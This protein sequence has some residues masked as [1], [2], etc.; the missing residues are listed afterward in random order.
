MDK[1]GALAVNA[2]EET[3]DDDV[4]VGVEAVGNEALV[5]EDVVVV[6]GVVAGGGA[7]TGVD[8]F[9]GGVGVALVLAVIAVR[10]DRIRR[11]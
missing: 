2:T 4:V 1:V 6:A 3:V 5:R 7:T 10:Q 8:D 9:A 11:D